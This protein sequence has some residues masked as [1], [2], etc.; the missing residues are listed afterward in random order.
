MFNSHLTSSD[1]WVGLLNLCGIVYAMYWNY[2]ASKMGL[3]AIFVTR[4]RV[5]AIA[6]VYFL[7]YLILLF[8]N[9]DPAHWSGTL[10]YFG[11]LAW[12]YVWA[13]PAKAAYEVAHHL[14]KALEEKVF[15]RLG[16]NDDSDEK[17]GNEE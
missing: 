11:I 15:E 7:A 16:K 9:V 8:S 12:I 6:F 4:I 10:R 17:D 14:G 3:G 13:I 2:K 5:V 1:I